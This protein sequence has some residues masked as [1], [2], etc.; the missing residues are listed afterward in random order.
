MFHSSM[1]P[2]P[3]DDIEEMDEVEGGADVPDADDGKQGLGV[4]FYRKWDEEREGFGPEFLDYIT[5]LDEGGHLDY[6]RVLESDI[7]DMEELSMLKKVSNYSQAVNNALFDIPVQPP[8]YY[9]AVPLLNR[10]YAQEICDIVKG[11]FSIESLF[12]TFPK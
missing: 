12:F 7:S 2:S 5:Q 4:L 8:F 3:P 6:G 9:M 1:L 10:P 11:S